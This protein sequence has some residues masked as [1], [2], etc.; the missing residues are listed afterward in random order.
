MSLL[1]HATTVLV[2]MTVS[3][4]IRVMISACIPIQS[5]VHVSMKSSMIHLYNYKPTSRSM[6]TKFITKFSTKYLLFLNTVVGKYFWL[7]QC[8]FNSC[9]R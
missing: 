2:S 7:Q 1:G 3:G 6:H 9:T 4:V 8:T 5:T